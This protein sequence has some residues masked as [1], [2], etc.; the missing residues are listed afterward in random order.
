MGDDAIINQAYEAM[1][2]DATDSE[3]VA[4]V[5]DRAFVKKG[6]SGY[7]VTFVKGNTLAGVEVYG[8]G[9]DGVEMKQKLIH[10]AGQVEG[11]L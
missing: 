10:A 3:P 8:E 6:N 2:A 7:T 11:R 9:S 1:K 5:G 4:G